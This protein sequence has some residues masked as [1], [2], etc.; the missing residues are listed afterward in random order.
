M[1]SFY[2]SSHCHPEFCWPFL[3]LP[4]FSLLFNRIVTVT[5]I[6]A[7]GGNNCRS[8]NAKNAERGAAR[9][10]RTSNRSY[11]LETDFCWCPSLFSDTTI[12]L[13]CIESESIPNSKSRSTAEVFCRFSIFFAMNERTSNLP[14]RLSPHHDSI[15]YISR[16]PRANLNWTS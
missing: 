6:Q 7:D 9:F 10:W 16:K 13:D 5:H 14:L 8:W 1:T 11:D 2:P 12:P 15:C 4:L 3:S